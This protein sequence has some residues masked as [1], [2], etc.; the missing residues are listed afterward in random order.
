MSKKIFLYDWKKKKKFKSIFLLK[1]TQK[2][3]E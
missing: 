2:N 3:N 1:I